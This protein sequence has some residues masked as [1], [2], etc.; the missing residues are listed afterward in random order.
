MADRSP[1]PIFGHGLTLARVAEIIAGNANISLAPEA[2]ERVAAS[3]AVVERVQSNDRALYGI[4]TGFGILANQ[5][6]ASADIEKLQENLILSHAVG[7]GDEVPREIVHLMLLLKVNALAI[8][9]SGVSLELIEYLIRFFNAR[10]TPVI[11]TKGSLGASG[12]LAPLAHLTLALLGREEVWLEDRRMTAQEAL[13]L[14]GLAP[15]KLKSKEGLALI[16]GTQFMLA[17]AVLC[18]FRIIDLLKTADLAAT[19]TLEALRGSASPFHAGLHE[20]RPHRGQIQTAENLRRILADSQILPSHADCRRV[21]DPYSLRCVPQVHGAIREAARHAQQIVETE[22]N[23]VTDNPLVFPDGEVVSGGNFHGEMLALVLDYLAIAT[24]ELASISERRLYLL[25]GGDT[26][27]ND[28]KVPTFLMRDTGL[29]SGF[30]V[31]QYTAAALVSENKVLA[32]PASV[33]SIPSSLGQEDHV[34]MGATSAT[35]LLE[36]VKNTE[37]VIAI[38]LMSAA[39]ALDFIHPL[40]AGKGVEAAHREIRKKISFADM[41]RIF[42]HD[43]AAALTLV[44]SRDLIRAAEEAIGPLHGV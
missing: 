15:L 24:A 7:V 31:P 10:V 33:D 16:N 22:I 20:A 41:D 26:V 37:T 28:K 36:I 21:Q 14:L 5:R 3:R 25:L 18:L 6:I 13:A 17:Y 34:S 4:N 27:P 38:E 42:V 9:L 19:M 35:K 44:R 8:G 2:A 29:N 1:L 11:F 43:I 32:H 23:S 39:Q 30:M 40:L 12:D